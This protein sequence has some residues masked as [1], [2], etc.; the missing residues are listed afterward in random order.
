[1]G[2]VVGRGLVERGFEVLWTSAGRGARS[3]ARAKAAGLTEVAMVRALTERAAVVLSICPPDAAVDVARAISG[4]G[5]GG[6]YVDAKAV[7]DLAHLRFEAGD[8]PAEVKVAYLVAD[9]PSN[10]DVAAAL[11]LSR[12]TVQTHVSHILAKLSARS[13]AEIIR[14]AVRHPAAR[15]TATA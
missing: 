3:A 1:M 7:L 13:R 2:S 15:E 4:A 9:G 12:N 6:T 8:W 5:F 14:E 11:F 10:P